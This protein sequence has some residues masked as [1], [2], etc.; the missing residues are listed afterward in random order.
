MGFDYAVEARVQESYAKGAKM[1]VQNI[2]KERK[3]AK[4][5]K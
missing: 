3:K 5:K 2:A 4:K 1:L